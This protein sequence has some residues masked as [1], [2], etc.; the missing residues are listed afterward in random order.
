MVKIRKHKHTPFYSYKKNNNN[1]TPALIKNE[2]NNNN[3]QENTRKQQQQQQVHK[4][5]ETPLK[6]NRNIT[7]S[8]KD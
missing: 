3:S 7:T 5:T 2:N 4:V 1:S 6:Q 8:F